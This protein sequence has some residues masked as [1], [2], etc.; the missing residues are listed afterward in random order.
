MLVGSAI[1]AWSCNMAMRK[2]EDWVLWEPAIAFDIISLS[3]AQRDKARPNFQDHQIPS[4]QLEEL[5]Y[6]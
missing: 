6:E 5:H 2:K 1:E 4:H 3:S